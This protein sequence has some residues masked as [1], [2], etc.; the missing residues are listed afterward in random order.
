MSYF[1]V[2]PEMARTIIVASA[3]GCA[4]QTLVLAAV[5]AG[6]K[7]LLVEPVRFGPQPTSSANRKSKPVHRAHVLRGV[8][9]WAAHYLDHG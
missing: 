7:D 9:T 4:E 2:D 1:P 8:N 6:D 3:L 5:L